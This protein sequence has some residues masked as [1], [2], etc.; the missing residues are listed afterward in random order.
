[1]TRRP[2]I[3]VNEQAEGKAGRKVAQIL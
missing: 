1:M 3:L 2:A